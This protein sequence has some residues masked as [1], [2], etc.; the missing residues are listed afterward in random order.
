MGH[1]Y[2]IFEHYYVKHWDKKQ[3][4]I[5]ISLHWS[6]LDE[7][8]FLFLSIAIMLNIAKWIYFF[9]LIK[10][11]RN[12]RLYEINEEISSNSAGLIQSASTNSELPEKTDEDNELL[13]EK[14]S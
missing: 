2:E 8:C 4:D 11:H 13:F 12:I 6:L 9:L 14:T 5:L 7:F 1:S 3:K 10:T